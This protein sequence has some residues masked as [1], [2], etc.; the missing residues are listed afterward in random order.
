MEATRRR[1]RRTDSRQGPRPSAMAPARR[2]ATLR[3][4]RSVF[5][6]RRVNRSRAR[7]APPAAAFSVAGRDTRSSTMRADL[8]RAALAGTGTGTGIPSPRRRASPALGALP[9]VCPL[10]AR[11]FATRSVSARVRVQRCRLVRHQKVVRGVRVRAHALERAQRG[12]VLSTPGSAMRRSNR[13]SGFGVGDPSSRAP[14]E[15][16][17]TASSSRPSRARRARAGLGKR[18]SRYPRGPR[19]G[20]ASLRQVLPRGTTPATCAPRVALQPAPSSGGRQAAPSELVAAARRFAATLCG[21]RATAWISSATRRA[22][23]GTP[24]NDRPRGASP[25][26][27]QRGRRGARRTRR[28]RTSFARGVAREAVTRTKR[29]ARAPAA[30]IRSSCAK[31][32]CRPTKGWMM[33]HPKTR[34][35]SQAKARRDRISPRPP[36]CSRRARGRRRPSGPDARASARIA[37]LEPLG[38]GLRRPLRDVQALQTRRATRERACRRVFPCP[39]RVARG[40]AFVVATFRKPTADRGPRSRTRTRSRRCARRDMLRTASSTGNRVANAGR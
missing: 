1:R 37:S 19:Q 18:C 40:P 3:E 31:T 15:W 21:A 22:P 36:S 11:A 4:R 33:I 20:A 26:A 23:F 6:S 39:G 27:A 38:R 7:R 35:F 29:C 5:V 8:A 16:A 12:D 14:Q 32:R 24:S 13:A 2:L 34:R 10:R 9:S 28:S 25:A 30:A 17:A